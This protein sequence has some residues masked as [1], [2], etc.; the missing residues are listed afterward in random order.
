M[1]TNRRHF[2]RPTFL[3][4]M[5]T[6]HN[7]NDLSSNRAH[8]ILR[9]ITGM[10]TPSE[11]TDHEDTNELESHEESEVDWDNLRSRLTSPWSVSSLSSTGSVSTR[12][13]SIYSRPRGMPHMPRRPMVRY[14]MTDIIAA[15]NARFDDHGSSDAVSATS[16]SSISVSEYR[17]GLENPE[18]ENASSLDSPSPSS[19]SLIS[20][21][22]DVASVNVASVTPPTNLYNGAQGVTFSCLHCVLEAM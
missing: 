6:D 14:S 16:R 18:A 1:P 11:P 4:F 7:A 21:P 3:H 13:A 12:P 22:H 20:L 19:S 9:W 5:S 15:R 2:Q 8:G 10:E 17:T